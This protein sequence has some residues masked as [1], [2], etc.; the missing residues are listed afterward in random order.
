[1]GSAVLAAT[2]DAL[3]ASRGPDGRHEAIAFWAGWTVGD[4]TVAAFAVVP[5]AD[6][7]WGHVRADETAMLRAARTARARG[8]GLLVQVHSHPGW[9]TRHSDGDDDLVHL[10]FEGMWSLV[11]ADFGAGAADPANGMGV[12]Q[13][14]DGQWVQV[15]DG[16]AAL[17]VLPALT[18]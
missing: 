12:H 4:T 8:A 16:T 11:V 6:H 1:V 5:D 17:V 14:Q 10:P 15:A 18:R 7:G 13:W 9:D 3:L 2:G